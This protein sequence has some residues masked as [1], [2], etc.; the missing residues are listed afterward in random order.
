MPGVVQAVPSKLTDSNP[1]DIETDVERMVIILL[2][3]VLR[4]V[5]KFCAKKFGYKEIYSQTSTW[6]TDISC[7]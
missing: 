2:N 4:V 5:C 6:G 7:M 1:I 3:C